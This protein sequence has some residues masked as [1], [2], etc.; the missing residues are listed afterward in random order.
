MDGE[1]KAESELGKGSV[2]SFSATFGKSATAHISSNLLT[3]FEG[4]KILL[5][6][7]QG[8][9]RQSLK[10]QIEGWNL[11]ATI[12][13]KNADKFEDINFDNSISAIIF[14][15]FSP[16]EEKEIIENIKVELDKIKIPLIILQNISE[17]NI[18]G[19]EIHNL[20]KPI[21]RSQLISVLRSAFLSEPFDEYLPEIDQSSS[22]ANE[23]SPESENGNSPAFPKANCF[24]WKMTL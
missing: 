19:N 7:E 4:K 24:W 13:D 23:F 20:T 1:I 10:S 11:Q 12:F 17:K 14:D 5:I 16:A 8:N 9:L 22:Y 2:F 18:F 6:G 21:R 3:D 15:T